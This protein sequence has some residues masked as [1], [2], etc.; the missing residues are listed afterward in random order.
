M[1]VRSLLVRAGVVLYGCWLLLVVVL[2]AGRYTPVPSVGVAHT[3]VVVGAAVLT[4]VGAAQIV[5][6][7]YRRLVAAAGSD[8]GP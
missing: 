5:R 1:T 6:A 8:D 4:V 3:G 7:G 2:L